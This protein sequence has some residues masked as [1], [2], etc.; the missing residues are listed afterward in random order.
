QWNGTN[1]AAIIDF[2]PA[3]CSAHP[4]VK[5]ILLDQ[6]RMNWNDASAN[7]LFEKCGTERFLEIV[8]KWL[9]EWD[10]LSKIDEAA[11]LIKD[12]RDQMKMLENGF[13]R[14]EELIDTVTDDLDE[15]L[16]AVKSNVKNLTSALGLDV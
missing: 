11:A 7:L 16:D 13:T 12:E 3:P 4:D 15:Y 1:T 2:M 8:K 9:Q 14:Y 10:L 5:E 6:H